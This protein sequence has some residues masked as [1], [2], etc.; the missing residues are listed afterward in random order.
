MLPTQ[1][2]ERECNYIPLTTKNFILTPVI[3]L[4]ARMRLICFY[5]WPYI[6]NV[7]ISSSNVFDIFGI[8]AH[9]FRNLF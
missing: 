8:A 7:G 4:S 3:S 1:F 2:K 9:V 6:L 5:P